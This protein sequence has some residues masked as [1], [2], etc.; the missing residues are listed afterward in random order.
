[1]CQVASGHSHSHTAESKVRPSQTA[2]IGL[3]AQSDSTWDVPV[4]PAPPR[5]IATTPAETKSPVQPDTTPAKPAAKANEIS[6]Q[7]SEGEAAGGSKGMTRSEKRRQHQEQLKN[8]GPADSGAGV[9]PTPQPKSIQPPHQPQQ[10]KT[11]APPVSATPAV[12]TP[13]PAKAPQQTPSRPPQQTPAAHA[14]HRQVDQRSHSSSTRPPTGNTAQRSTPPVKSPPATP[15]PTPLTRETAFAGMPQREIVNLNARPKPPTDSAREQKSPTT[16]P[17]GSGTVAVTEQL[18]QQLLT[19]ISGATREE[20]RPNFQV[21]DEARGY[22]GRLHKVIWNEL[23]TDDQL[24]FHRSDVRDKILR[25]LQMVF[26]DAELAK[27]KLPKFLS[28]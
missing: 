6:G 15:P 5:R 2:P 13:T 19:I 18:K 12:K 8:K 27:I 16:A 3:V 17:A 4:L 1:M 25:G 10:T 23:P 22:L 9:V 20:G 24:K 28:K 11:P 7:G 21:R 14:P 26:G